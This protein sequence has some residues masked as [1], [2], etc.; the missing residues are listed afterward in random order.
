MVVSLLSATE[1]VITELRRECWVSLVLQY[2]RLLQCITTPCYTDVRR[3]PSEL[4]A[5]VLT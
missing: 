4:T 2:M 1:G 5:L 3:H